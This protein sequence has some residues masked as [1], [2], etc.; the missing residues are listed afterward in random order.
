MTPAPRPDASHG[1]RAGAEAVSRRRAQAV[2]VTVGMRVPSQLFEQAPSGLRACV[3]RAEAVGIDRLSVGDHVSFHGGRGF[4]GMVQAAVLAGLTS[5]IEVQTGVYLLGLRH[6]VLA[7]R[8]IATVANLASGRLIVGVGLGGEDPHELEVCGV[9][10]KTR[11]RRL[12]ECLDVVRALLSGEPLDHHGRF[13]DLDDARILPAASSPVP[14]VVG[15]RSDAAIRRAA[16]R[17]EGWLGLFVS[18]DRYHGATTQVEEVA[19]AE[20]RTEVP[21]RHG[22]HVWCSFDPTPDRVAAAME[23]LYKT[24][25]ARFERYTPVGSPAE[26]ADQLGPYVVNGLRHVNLAPVSSTAEEAIDGVAEVKRL[27]AAAAGERRPD[28][29]GGGPAQDA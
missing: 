13:F 21:W 26:V 22:M 15:G 12:D 10:P 14:I 1:P 5:T 2:G 19:V 11:G 28:G 17:A 16:L 29:D 25:F 18:A 27:L 3:A 20:G 4:D 23:D 8:Q 9:D 6:P 24:P 7:A